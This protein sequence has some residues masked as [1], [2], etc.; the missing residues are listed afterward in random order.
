MKCINVL[1]AAVALA[2]TFAAVAGCSRSGAETPREAIERMKQAIAEG[3]KAAFTKVVLA[4]SGNAKATEFLDMTFQTAHISYK[5]D[6]EMRAAYGRGLNE[7]VDT[8]ATIDVAA[9]N[10][11]E[12]GDKASARWKGGPGLRLARREGR[13]FID[14][15]LPP[16][17]DANLKLGSTILQ[18]MQAA[19]D[20]VGKTGYTADRI[21]SEFAAELSAA[22]AA[23]GPGATAKSRPATGA[24]RTST[25]PARPQTTTRPLSVSTRRADTTSRP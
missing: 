24:A 3:D 25:R 6:Q 8:L 17:L 20:K 11:T 1:G 5:L 2:L 19:R 4:D 15:D 16:N 12:I 14:P 23:A 10:I 21:A 13:W 22:M 18:A 7:G 9:M